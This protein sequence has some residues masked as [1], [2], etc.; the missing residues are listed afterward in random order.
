MRALTAAPLDE[1]DLD[2]RI[3]KLRTGQLEATFPELAPGTPVH[4]TLIRH[5]FLFGTTIEPRL[6]LQE[7]PGVDARQYQSRLQEY[8]NAARAEDALQWRTMEP[9]QGQT[10]AGDAAAL[11]LWQKCDVLGVALRGHAIFDGAQAPAWLSGLSDDD[12][13]AALQGR[14]D[15]MFDLLGDKIDEWDLNDGMLHRDLLAERLGFK[16]G[17]VWFMWAGRAAPRA[18]LCLNEFDLLAPDDFTS[19]TAKIRD[20]HK[21]GARI[22]ALGVRARFGAQAPSISTV[23]KRLEALRQF[24]VPLRITDFALEPEAD[25]ARQAETYR[26]LMKLF[27]AHPAV[28][29]VD[30]PEFWAGAAGAPNGALWDRQW[31]PGATGRVFAQLLDDTWTTS[32]TAP[33]DDQHAVALQGYFGLY[34]LEAEGRTWFVK[35]NTGRPYM[36]AWMKESAGP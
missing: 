18:R 30:Q 2:A 19:L 10:A 33:V 31:R 11:A 34:R 16:N 32:G 27:F 21:N 15:H 22:S 6:L 13:Q 7:P 24:S 17:L 1:A 5:D 36:P 20:L 14:L 23:W 35:W 26:R 28:A 4:Y 8:F 29:G 25:D 3:A 12:L 9:Q